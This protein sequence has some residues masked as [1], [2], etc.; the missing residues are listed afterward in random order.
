VRNIHGIRPSVGQKILYVGSVKFRSFNSFFAFHVFYIIS[1]GEKKN[2]T[3]IMTNERTNVSPS[4]LTS[5]MGNRFEG[6]NVRIARK[7]FSP[8]NVIF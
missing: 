1:K 3:Q 4:V 8:V 6:D 7:S 5:R 2:A